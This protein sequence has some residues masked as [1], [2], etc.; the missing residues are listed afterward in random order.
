MYV[1]YIYSLKRNRIYISRIPSYFKTFI[2]I[3]YL[4]V[5]SLIRKAER[6]RS[7]REAINRRQQ[8][9]DDATAWR[10]LSHRRDRAVDFAA[11][12]TRIPPGGSFL[13]RHIMVST[14]PTP[15]P[16]TANRRRPCRRGVNEWERHGRPGQ[17]A[18][19]SDNEMCQFPWRGGA[20]PGGFSFCRGSDC[21]RR[22]E[23][24]RSLGAQ[25]TTRRRGI[26]RTLHNAPRRKSF[27]F[28]SMNR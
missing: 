3:Y 26:S 1:I 21:A 14:T 16:W 7:S 25:R 8:S 10:D 19:Q 23:A 2:F 27:S 11:V 15:S 17:A 24:G 5:P 12:R 20:R 6:A 4:P 28:S 13:R 9:R 18:E 22:K